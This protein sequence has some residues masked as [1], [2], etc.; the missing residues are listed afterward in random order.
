MLIHNKDDIQFVTEFPCLFGHPVPSIIQITESIDQF[1]YAIL[2][3][4][5]FAMRHFLNMTFYVKKT[6]PAKGE[7]FKSEFLSHTLIFGSSFWWKIR[8]FKT[9]LFFSSPLQV[10]VARFQYSMKWVESLLQTQIFYL[11]KLESTASRFKDKWIRKSEFV[12]KT[13]FLS[14]HLS[15]INYNLCNE[16]QSS[17]RTN[18]QLL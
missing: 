5:I 16:A 9:F 15:W 17:L 4:V 1:H 13:E 3:C 18:K 7:N 12:A 8:N 10:E 14:F 11:K 6:P 2:D